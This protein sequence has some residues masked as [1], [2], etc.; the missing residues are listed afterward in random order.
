MG[1]VDRVYSDELADFHEA[2]SMNLARRDHRR[3][4]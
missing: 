3:F 2:V 1:A 4:E